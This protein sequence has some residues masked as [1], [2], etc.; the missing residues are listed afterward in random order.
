MSVEE[1]NS[2]KLSSPFSQGPKA[3]VSNRGYAV[4]GKNT[5]MSSLYY[6]PEKPT[7]FS[8]LDKLSEALPKKTSLMSQHGY[9]MKTPI[10]C[11]GLS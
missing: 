8:T 3:G 7:E 11:I 4:H 9:N 6:N 2:A 1:K 10:R 5:K